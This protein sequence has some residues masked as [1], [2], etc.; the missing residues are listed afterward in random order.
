MTPVGHFVQLNAGM[1]KV[2]LYVAHATSS[3]DDI[4]FLRGQAE[5][6]AVTSKWQRPSGFAVRFGEENKIY[7]AA[8]LLDKNH[9]V[10]GKIPVHIIMTTQ[11]MEAGLEMAGGLVVMDPGYYD[12][13][14]VTVT[15]GRHTHVKSSLSVQI[16]PVGLHSWD[17]VHVASTHE[18]W[19]RIVQ[20]L[21]RQCQKSSPILT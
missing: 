21:D 13:L 1:K 15:H 5:L 2:A 20:N 16:I 18:E 14:P 8:F 17:E 7:A 4:S 6:L 9:C 10:C 19:K 3:Y 11:G 12:P